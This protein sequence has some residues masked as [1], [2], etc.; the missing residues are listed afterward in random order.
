MILRFEENLNPGFHDILNE[1][2]WFPATLTLGKDADAGT[3]LSGPQLQWRFEL[4]AFIPSPCADTSDNSH[5]RG[6]S[7]TLR[8]SR[9]FGRNGVASSRKTPRGCL[10]Y[11]KNAAGYSF[12]N[13]RELQSITIHV[14]AERPVN[15]AWLPKPSEA[16]PF[17]G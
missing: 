10:L 7:M 8:S 6:H 2:C 4:H 14:A 5:S 9:M 16:R 13:N 1:E 17:V 3:G 11:Q 15:A 12:N